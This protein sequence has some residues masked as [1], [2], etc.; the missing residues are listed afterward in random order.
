L[1][2]CGGVRFIWQNGETGLRLSW[3]HCQ[4]LPPERTAPPASGLWWPSGRDD[5]CG[6]R[7][8]DHQAPINPLGRFGCTG[9]RAL[10]STMTC[11]RGRLTG[12]SFH[13]RH[14]YPGTGKPRGSRPDRSSSFFRGAALPCGSHRPGRWG[15]YAAISP[16]TKIPMLETPVRPL[17]WA[18]RW[19][20]RGKASS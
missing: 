6:D 11:E 10:R 5:L 12:N 13:N 4:K 16:E 15:W 17:V 7:G 18:G 2:L 3:R 1:G 19:Q 14:V 8:S 9:L 20:R